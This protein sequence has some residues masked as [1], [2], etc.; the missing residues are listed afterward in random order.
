MVLVLAGDIGGT[1]ARFTLF[2]VAGENLHRGRLAE[3]DPS[4]DQAVLF[5]AYRN[6]DFGFFADILGTF[7]SVA[8]E[9]GYEGVTAACFAVAG[10]V[11]ENRINFTNREGWILD[12]EDIRQAFN[13][14]AVS[15]INDFVANGYGLLTLND[16]DETVTLQ[17]GAVC[18]N[19][20]IACVGAG[21]G[22]GE[23]FL[24]VGRD[25]LYQCY[26]SEGGHVEFFPRDELEDQ[27]L[28]HLRNK[29][30][31]Q[32]H[33]TGFKDSAPPRIS[34]ERVVS[35]LGLYNVYDF[36]R[37]RFPE[38]RI[39]SLDEEI[40]EARD[41]GFAI[42]RT[43]YDY[44]LAEKA[45]RM[46]FS[47][48]GAEVGNVALKY[49]P[50]G[51]LY[52][53]GGIAPKNIE[54]IRGEG[55]EFLQSLLRKG[56]VSGALQDI[57][58]KVVMKEDIG[59]RGAHLAAL[60]LARDVLELPVASSGPTPLRRGPTDASVP[61]FIN[62]PDHAV[63]D[64]VPEPNVVFNLSWLNMTSRYPVLTSTLTSS[65]VASTV[66]LLAV[67]FGGVKAGSRL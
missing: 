7:L 35:G 23:C 26:S 52:V 45:V 21:T 4:L 10:P 33:S 18:P 19:A 60:R 11:R 5:E 28:N 2:S 24:T 50:Y 64:S 43:A 59:I 6:D 65:I 39:E 67:H 51:G 37:D 49:L 27:L 31:S 40:L 15:L 56:R 46:M 62:V 63:L 20:P 42:A 17:E 13:I 29:F 54:R 61:S 48:Y 9:R 55:S 36:L 47:I 12:A 57:P 53:A 30:A 34:V 25:G 58:I 14:Q 22:L 66:A 32:G 8:R 3:V 1:N 38:E 41:R 16:M 44:P